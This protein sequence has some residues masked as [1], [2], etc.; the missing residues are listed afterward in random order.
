MAKFNLGA[1]KDDMGTSDTYG[2]MQTKG[3]IPKKKWKI[4]HEKEQSVSP[5]IPGHAVSYHHTLPH[6]KT[7]TIELTPKLWEQ[8]LK[9]HAG[10]VAGLT[11][12]TKSTEEPRN[13]QIGDKSNKTRTISFYK[14]GE[15]GLYDQLKKQFVSGMRSEHGG[16]ASTRSFIKY[17]KE[18]NIKKS[19]IIDAEAGTKEYKKVGRKRTRH[20]KRGTKRDLRPKAAKIDDALVK[21]K[22]KAEQKALLIKQKEAAEAI[23]LSK[24]KKSE[25]AGHTDLSVRQTNPRFL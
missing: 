1:G 10:D 16:E 4:T 17:D 20:L 2:A 25:A 23:T 13:I 6:K 11:R 24:L 14:Q 15:E 18:G 8:Q 22:Q 5:D 12:H 3:L 21:A 19:S 7:P 9:E